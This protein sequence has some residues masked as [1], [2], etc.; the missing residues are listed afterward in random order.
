MF[1]FLSK[2]SKPMDDKSGL[3]RVVI[4]V[5]ASVGTGI[6]FVWIVFAVSS[7]HSQKWLSLMALAFGVLEMVFW[8]FERI[9]DRQEKSVYLKSKPSALPEEE[10][11]QCPHCDN[12]VTEDQSFCEGCKGKLPSKRDRALLKT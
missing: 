5:T 7:Q 6:A 11:L 12:T 8:R 2:T 9:L 3:W 4:Q 1:A 10:V